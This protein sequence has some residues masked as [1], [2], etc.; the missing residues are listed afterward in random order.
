VEETGV[1]GEN[2][3]PAAS[4][5]QTLS[6]NVVSSTPRH[7]PQHPLSI[8]SER[9]LFALLIFVDG[10]HFLNFLFTTIEKIISCNDPFIVW[11]N[12]KYDTST[13]LTCQWRHDLLLSVALSS[14]FLNIIRKSWLCSVLLVFIVTLSNYSD[15]SRLPDVMWEESPDGYIGCRV[16][17]CTKQKLWPAARSLC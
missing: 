3:R 13:I 4:H 7:G 1:P 5:C 16:C 9:L 8:W 2:H 15:V 6:H 10:H 11:Q 17:I 12:V 14:L